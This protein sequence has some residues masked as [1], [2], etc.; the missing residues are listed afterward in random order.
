MGGI[1][2]RDENATFADGSILWVRRD[3]FPTQNYCGRPSAA[4]LPGSDWT[5]GWRPYGI[6]GPNRPAPAISELNV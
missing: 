3:L 6:R 5:A 2:P 1:V 4:G